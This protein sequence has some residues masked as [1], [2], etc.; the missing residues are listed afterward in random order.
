M[1]VLVICAVLFL[2]IFSNSSAETEDDFLEDESFEAD[3][4]IPFLAREQVRSDCTL[5]N[6][7]C[8]DDR[9]S[10][11][12]SKM[13]KDVCKCFYPSQRSDTARA[14]K[15]LCTCQQD[16]HLKFIEKGLQKAKVLVAG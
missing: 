13:F 8:T 6:H 5:R 2:T 14:K 9:H 12:R 16:K 1:K 7:D 10:C 11:C 15:E 4:V 3:D